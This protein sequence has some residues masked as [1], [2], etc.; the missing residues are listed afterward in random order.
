VLIGVQSGDKYRTNMEPSRSQRVWADPKGMEEK[1]RVG[2]GWG[3][4]LNNT[5]LKRN[6]REP[7]A[8]PG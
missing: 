3:K 1:Q 5:Q 8:I 6:T 2:W 4:A 7:V